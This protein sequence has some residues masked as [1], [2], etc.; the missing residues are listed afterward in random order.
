MVVIDI[1]CD[2]DKVKIPLDFFAGLAD[3]VVNELGARIALVAMNVG[4]DTDRVE[5]EAAS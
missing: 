5:M 4:E 3:H 2:I 1:A